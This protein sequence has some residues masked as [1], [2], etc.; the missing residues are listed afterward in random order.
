LLPADMRFDDMTKHLRE[1]WWGGL[2]IDYRIVSDLGVDT[3]RTKIKIYIREYSPPPD[4]TRRSTAPM[5]DHSG[6]E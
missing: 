5:Q 2:K 3:P 6:A 1:R 4:E